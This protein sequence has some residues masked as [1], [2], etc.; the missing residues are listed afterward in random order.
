MKNNAPTNTSRR[1]FLTNSAVAA[2]AAGVAAS[3]IGATGLL[4]ST[5]AK[6]VSTNAHIVIVGAGAAGL[7]SPHAWSAHSMAPESRSSTAAK[8]IS[9]SRA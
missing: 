8:C 1:R 2:G 4:G 3:G 6:A 7:P 5:P 9:I